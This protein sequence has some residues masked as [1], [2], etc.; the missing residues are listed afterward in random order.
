MSHQ[1][2]ERIEK[3]K[4][5]IIG[6]RFN[7][8]VVKGYIPSCRNSKVKARAIC[9]CD[10]GN[11]RIIDVQSLRSKGS[12]S[13]GCLRD[14]K[15]RERKTIHGMF[16]SPEYLTWEN[17]KNRCYYEKDA[18][19]KHYGARGIKICDSW[20][21]KKYGF[22]NF[23]KDMGSRPSKEHS[24]DRINNDGNYE[25]KNCRWATRSEQR[26]N[27]RKRKN[28]ITPPRSSNGRFVK[29]ENKN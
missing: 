25:P 9:L 29:R 2:K 18:S 16:K 1:F 11:S 5:N 7:R 4:A 27:Q 8:L 22:L 24:I 10:C 3:A 12:Q 6:R 15:V 21:D 17:M 20:L 28:Y 26:R 23:F 13:C 19:Y 14:E